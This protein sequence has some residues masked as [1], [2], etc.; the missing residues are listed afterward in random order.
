MWNKALNHV[1]DDRRLKHTHVWLDFEP[2]RLLLLVTLL[3]I[4]QDKQI[5]KRRESFST[6]PVTKSLSSSVSRS[7]RLSVRRMPPDHGKGMSC[8]HSKSLRGQRENFLIALA[9]H[10]TENITASTRHGTVIIVISPGKPFL[11]PSR[12]KNSQRSVPM[13]CRHPLRESKGALCVMKPGDALIPFNLCS[14]PVRFLQTTLVWLIIFLLHGELIITTRHLASGRLWS[15]A[16]WNRRHVSGRWSESSGFTF[17]Y[18]YIRTALM[19]MSL[20]VCTSKTTRGKLPRVRIGFP[21]KCANPFNH[22]DTPHHRKGA[23]FLCSWSWILG[24]SLFVL[25]Q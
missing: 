24:Y 20:C 8:H 6:Y 3:K 4:P 22:R 15:S 23:L 7:V 2:L 1:V 25:L 19:P 14:H 17:T 18:A 9:K 11:G 5:N 10:N 13:T 16:V 12:P 21:D